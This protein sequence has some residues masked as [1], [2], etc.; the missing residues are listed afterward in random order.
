MEKEAAAVGKRVKESLLEVVGQRRFETWF[1]GRVGFLTPGETVLEVVVQTTLERDC[2]Q[3]QFFAEL[4]QAC[5]LAGER[6]RRIV[7][8]VDAGREARVAEV[9]ATVAAATAA[10]APRNEAA[11][12]VTRGQDQ[13][14]RQ[15]AEPGG[16]RPSPFSTLVTG[17]G[18]VAAV[19]IAQ[20]I[21]AGEPVASPLLI[22]G[23]TGVGKTHLLRSIRQDV[24]RRKRRIRT[25]YLTAEQFTTGFVEAVHGRG[26]PSFR[27]KHRGV[28]LLL[29]DD[30]QFFLAKPKTL[31]ELQHTF[32]HLIADG[33]TIVA[34]A[35]RP[36]TGLQ[37][38]G[39]DLASR[40]SAGLSI[41]IQQPD[42]KTR[43]KLLEGIAEAAGFPL[44]SVI[45]DAVAATVIGGARELTG[46][47]NRLRVAS[48]LTGDHVTVDAAR[49]LAEETNS[50]TTP[51]IKMADIQSAVC[52]VFGV[53]K[54]V[55]R[56]DKRTRAV[57]EPRMLA[58]WLSRK[59]TRAA[60][61]E[62]G[63]YFGRRSH[64]TVISAC[65]RVDDL[66]GRDPAVRG[67]AGD[68]G[69]QD[70]LR[71]IEVELRTA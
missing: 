13:S 50:Q 3:R 49:R 37:G 31:E 20:Q 41:E 8:R 56:S 21:A 15:A 51:R 24:R 4:E 7:F 30:L 5:R 6:E 36:P 19:S 43:R 26:L 62:I 33:A 45:V 52:R 53:D 22:W 44:P 48:E 11:R 60:W 42:Y 57:T 67:G 2:L 35:D 39:G 40:L 23:P 25:I 58:M 61:S 70:A 34:A 32:D 16:G 68:H 18:N 38:L 59:Y 46:V 29:L 28:D 14:N 12:V 63:A 17:E 27:S 55:L 9:K 47:F 69:L 71:Q 54:G 64:S 10:E 66:V 1:G 65:R